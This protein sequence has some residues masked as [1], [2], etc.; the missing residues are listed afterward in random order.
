MLLGCYRRG[1]AAD[2]DT[3]AAAIAVVL[4]SYQPHIVAAVVDPVKGLPSRSQFL[5]T[6]KEVRDACEELY[7][8]DVWRRERPDRIERQLRERQNY[9]REEAE[10]R[11]TYAELQARCAQDGLM[12][13]RLDKAC[14]TTPEAK[15]AAARQ[16][17]D[18]FDVSEEVWNA[19]P[20]AR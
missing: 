7:R 17:K 20:N 8:A 2:P 15:A 4:A 16:F 6:V 1:D 5:P 13:G 19:I 3:Y 14:L 10:R 11:L 9:Q 18:Q 12:I